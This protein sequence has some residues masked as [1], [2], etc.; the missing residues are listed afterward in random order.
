M[1]EQRNS[2]QHHSGVLPLE[3]H[4]RSSLSLQTQVPAFSRQL[5]PN[6]SVT[7]SK[8]SHFESLGFIF[9][10]EIF[11]HSLMTNFPFSSKLFTF[12]QSKNVAYSS[13]NDRLCAFYITGYLRHNVSH[14]SYEPLTGGAVMLL[15]SVRLLLPN[16]LHDKHRRFFF[17]F[18]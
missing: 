8:L 1:L 2:S 7:Y 6:I 5:P 4:P 12:L 17:F 10:V 9:F 13:G 11:R 14:P 16:I 3:K 18:S 15:F